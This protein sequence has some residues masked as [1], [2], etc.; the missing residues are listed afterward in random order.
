[1]KHITNPDG[2][3]LKHD[4][5]PSQGSR[6]SSTF[7]KS[8]TIPVRVMSNFFWDI[9]HVASFLGAARD[10]VII[11]RSLPFLLG[12][13]YSNGARVLLL[14]SKEN[15]DASYQVARRTRIPLPFSAQV[16]ARAFCSTT[17]LVARSAS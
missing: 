9:Y 6:L 5:S 15:G 16:S 7:D 10:H 4:L 1:M 14:S 12:S 13:W 8:I 17:A 11:S 2:T 3:R